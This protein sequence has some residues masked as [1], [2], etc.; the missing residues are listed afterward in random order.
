LR[1]REDKRCFRIRKRNS[2]EQ[3][4]LQNYAEHFGDAELVVDYKDA[5]MRF[6]RILHLAKG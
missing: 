5:G 3:M 4:H 1:R 2:V 6:K